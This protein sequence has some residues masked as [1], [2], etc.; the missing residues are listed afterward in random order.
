MPRGEP[1]HTHHLAEAGA[2]GPPGQGGRLG[3]LRR[4]AARPCP[5]A[6]QPSGVGPQGE[7]DR[8][9]R[10]AGGRQAPCSH[11]SPMTLVGPLLP[12]LGQRVLAGRMLARR[13]QGG[14]VTRQRQAAAEEVPGRPPLRGRAI[15]LREQAPPEQH[16]AG[17]GGALVVWGRAPLARLPLQGGAQDNRPPCLGPQVG[18]PVPGKET[19]DGDDQSL[20][21]GREGLEKRLRRGWPVPMEPARTVRVEATGGPGP[22][23]QVEATGKWVW[24]GGEAQAVSSS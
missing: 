8:D 17:L 21:R 22:G 10:R 19:G 3:R 23:R 5:I 14:A 4:L 24:L 7:G 2:R 20:A 11:P 15:G 16:G 18:A 12:A 9:A 13:Q 6:A 1:P